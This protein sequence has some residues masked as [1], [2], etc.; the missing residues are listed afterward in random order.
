MEAGAMHGTHWQLGAVT[1]VLLLASS[2]ARAEMITAN[3][4]GVD[5][6]VVPSQPIGGSRFEGNPSATPTIGASGNYQGVTF[7]WLAIMRFQNQAD[8]DANKNST[9]IVMPATPFTFSV[10][11]H[12]NSGHTAQINFAGTAS[13]Q[14][15]YTNPKLD[16]SFASSTG[17]ATVGGAVVNVA[18]DVIQHAN[19]TPA[20]TYNGG[21][22]IDG[23]LPIVTD[24]QATISVAWPQDPGGG[25][26]AGGGSGGDGTGGSNP[27]GGPGVPEPASLALACLAVGGLFV[28]RGVGAVTDR[29]PHRR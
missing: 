3:F 19:V 8:F 1:T 27:S 24:L 16:I 18:L 20:V 4:Y 9:I 11:L 15:S 5:F 14:M 7:G 12:D 13:G 26:G 17:Q 25:S 23:P 29:S 2:M 28:R 10:G 22:S 6:A 21:V